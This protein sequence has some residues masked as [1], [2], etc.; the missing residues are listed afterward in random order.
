MDVDKER[1]LLLKKSKPSK[2]YDASLNIVMEG[3]IESEDE[4]GINAIYRI[5]A[6]YRKHH[7]RVL[8]HL[9]NRW[10]YYSVMDIV[11]IRNA[12]LG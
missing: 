8:E 1:I 7:I 3:E 2:V 5:N 4:H 12:K 6:K 10:D 9:A 11:E